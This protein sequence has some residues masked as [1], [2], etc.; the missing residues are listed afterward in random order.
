MKT[1]H[2]IKIILIFGLA[3]TIIFTMEKLKEPKFDYVS[4]KKIVYSDFST[5]QL[6]EEIQKILFKEK[7]NYPAL[8]GKAQ[9]KNDI[10]SFNLLKQ[11]VQRDLL[12]FD[13]LIAE[14]KHRKDYDPYLLE[15]FSTNKQISDSPINICKNYIEQ[16]TDIFKKYDAL[17]SIIIT[18]SYLTNQEK[19]KIIEIFNA[20]NK[21]DENQQYL[22]AKM[23]KL[24]SIFSLDGIN[25]QAKLLP[26][27]VFPISDYFR[28]GATLL[29]LM[30][31]ACLIGTSDTQET[32]GGISF[33]NKISLYPLDYLIKK[34]ASLTTP[35]NHNV[36]PFS[37]LI[38]VARE[39]QV[40]KVITHLFAQ[41][42]LTAF[43]TTFALSAIIVLFNR[44]FLKGL[45]EQALFV[46]WLSALGFI[47]HTKFEKVAANNIL[48]NTYKS[49]LFDNLINF[50][51]KLKNTHALSVNRNLLIT[52]NNQITS[53]AIISKQQPVSLADQYTPLSYIE[54]FFAY[55]MI[56]ARGLLLLQKITETEHPL[57]WWAQLYNW[58][59]R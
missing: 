42:T 16:Q 33:E 1:H 27:I 39:V 7:L 49:T 47:V 5:N 8:M 58:V 51:N 54:R 23:Y 19:Q 38:L 41:A 32:I 6:V 29:H 56:K 2:Y 35:N 24:L 20:T 59:T 44:S 21:L 17:M 9:A 57:S 48:M 37:M 26:G 13:K 15:L 53:Y 43:T 55:T 52:A 36:T 14:Y 12:R 40:K 30:I 46:I 4:E 10:I 28:D 18:I 22:L 11:Q 31:Y 3:S 25:S 45:A 50:I 34:G